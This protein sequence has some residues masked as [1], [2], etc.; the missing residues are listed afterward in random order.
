MPRCG[1]AFDEKCV[2]LG[3]GGTAGGLEVA[4]RSAVPNPS[5]TTT[6]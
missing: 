2:P 5:F 4:V 3:Q 1:A 6:P